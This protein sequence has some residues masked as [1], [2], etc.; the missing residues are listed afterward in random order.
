MY[1]AIYF[2]GI[3]QETKFVFFV[4]VLINDGPYRGIMIHLV[5][6]IPEDYPLIGPAGNIA[7]GLEFDQKYHEH[8][9]NDYQYDHVL[10]HIFL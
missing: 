5:L 2:N 6:H 10:D 4:Q 1:L 7:P 3:Q 8:I 9:H